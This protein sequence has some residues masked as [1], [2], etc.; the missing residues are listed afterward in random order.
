MSKHAIRRS[1]LHAVAFLQSRSLIVLGLALVGVG[2]VMA[3]QEPHGQHSFGQKLLCG[4][5]CFLWALLGF[6]KWLHK[7]RTNSR[8]HQART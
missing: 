1:R 6:D 5:G 3:I 4:G 2:M 7:A 8:I